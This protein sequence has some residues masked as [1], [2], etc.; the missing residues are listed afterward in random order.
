MPNSHENL[1]FIVRMTSKHL[2][3]TDN[4]VFHVFVVSTDDKFSNL[5]KLFK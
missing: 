2:S 5:E 1:D 4:S 3:S